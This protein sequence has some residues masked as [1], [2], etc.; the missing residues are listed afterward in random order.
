ML[1]RR[2]AR[3]QRLVHYGEDGHGNQLSNQAIEMVYICIV[4]TALDI[5]RMEVEA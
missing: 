4:S 5:A 1:R 3:L 2:L